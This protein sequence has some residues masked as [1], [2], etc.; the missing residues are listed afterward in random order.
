MLPGEM[1]LLLST[2]ICWACC[3]APSSSASQGSCVHDLGKSSSS[4]TLY[5]LTCGRQ[6]L[7]ARAL[8]GAP[9]LIVLDRPFQLLPRGTI[10]R[11]LFKKI[12]QSVLGK[13]I[14]STVVPASASPS[15]SRKRAFTA[16]ARF[17]YPDDARDCTTRALVFDQRGRLI[18]V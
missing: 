11:A 9:S 5:L 1:M 14:S 10:E 6:V 7:L 15:S 3:Y 2:V 16:V 8:V 13:V 17:D 4:L 18:E 12:L